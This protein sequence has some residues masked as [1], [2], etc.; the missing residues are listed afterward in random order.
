VEQQQIVTAYW[1]HYA[2]PHDSVWA[3]DLVDDI[4]HGVTHASA[5]ALTLFADLAT[6]AP[7][8]AALS[9]LGA[10]PLEDYLRCSAL[11]IERLAVAITTSERLKAAFRYAYLP[12][13]P[14]DLNARLRGLGIGPPRRS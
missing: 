2:D 12:D 10:G 5:D 9:Y 14:P 4:G 1:R 7:D 6:A 8:E 3:W 13:E 11:D